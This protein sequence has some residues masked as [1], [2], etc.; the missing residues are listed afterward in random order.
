MKRLPFRAMMF[1]L[2][3]LAWI[4]TG[5]G[6]STAQSQAP[7]IVI[8]DFEGD[9]YGTWTVE[10]TAFGRGPARGT[11]PGQM[12]VEGFQG[13]GLVNSF[14]GG[15][16]STGRLISPP[17][18]IRRKSIRFLIGGGG[19]TGRTCMN[20]DRQRQGRPHR[21][22][23]RTPSPA[24]ASASSPAA[25]TSATSPGRPLGSRSSTTRP[26]DGVTSTSTRSSSPTAS[27][28]RR[29]TTPPAR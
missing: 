2:S 21:R 22:P 11:L 8:A 26:A 27:R 25:G 16:G 18:A 19:W 17:F 1:V 5:A 28:P 4:A 24:A 13:R 12:A 9:D 15:D 3:S 20:L 29:S 7:D 14:S 6:V 10:G 23:V